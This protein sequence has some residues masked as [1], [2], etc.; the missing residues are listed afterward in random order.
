MNA[1]R[2]DAVLL[3]SPK[4]EAL[5]AFYRDR[6]GIPF[7]E[8]RHG[9]APHWACFLG[10]VHFA[11]H[12]KDGAAGAVRNVSLSFEVADVDSAVERLQKQGV[13]IHLQPANRP[14]GRLA[15]I[16][17]PNG[18]LVYLHHY[19]AVPSQRPQKKK[20]SGRKR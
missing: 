18:N 15:A 12:Q 8:E 17:D 9:S 13:L 3:D 14:Y 7:E 10:G 11:I 19:P 1:K 6:L 5:A 20:A 4:A 16:K 2:I